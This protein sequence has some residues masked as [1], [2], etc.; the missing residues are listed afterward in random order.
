M[1]K[2]L[3]LFLLIPF[4]GIAQD[5]T[6][7]TTQEVKEFVPLNIM[8]EYEKAY[9]REEKTALRLGFLNYNDEYFIPFNLLNNYATYTGTPIIEME[10]KFGK[11]ISIKAGLGLI[12]PQY[13]MKRFQYSIPAFFDLKYYLNQKNRIKSGLQNNNF[14]GSYIGLRYL[15][16]NMN[17]VN[18]DTIE[19]ANFENAYKEFW[20]N[21]AIELFYGV[22]FG[23]AYD[24]KFIFGVRQ[25]FDLKKVENDFLFFENQRSFY[26]KTSQ[27]VS[28]DFLKNNKKNADCDILNCNES[29]NN[30]FK[31]K[32]DNPINIGK[33][34]KMLN[35]NVGFERRIKQSNTTLNTNLQAIFTNYKL[36]TLSYFENGGFSGNILM[37][38]QL[39]TALSLGVRQYLFKKQAILKGQEAKNLNGI[40]IEIGENIN[41]SYIIGLDN[42]QLDR[43][44]KKLYFDGYLQFGNQ[45]IYAQKYFVNYFA[46]FNYIPNR[47]LPYS[48]LNL[49]FRKH[50]F[51][52]GISAGL[53]K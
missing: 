3:L 39:G 2:L 7:Y 36:K 25:N 35:L 23:T 17:N 38:N 40:Y 6:S 1:K 8:D 4:F 12:R 13:Q 30:A 49:N 9:G 21:K 26:F 45:K 48:D 33:N 14:N 47:V 29:L 18:Y 31:L 43:L 42:E 46:Q 37:F 34:T 16:Y 50:N 44:L 32:L 10:Q 20:N 51:N 28:V 22:Q 24:F 5:S 11:S 27:F 52:F 53:I 15:A 19:Y 41:K